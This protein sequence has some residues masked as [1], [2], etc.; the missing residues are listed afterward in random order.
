MA[1]KTEENREETYTLSNDVGDSVVV[2]ITL[3]ITE[4]NEEET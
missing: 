2:T 3:A 1:E 4:E